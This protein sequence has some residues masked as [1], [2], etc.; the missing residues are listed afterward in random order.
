MKAI[1]KAAA[2]L[3]KIVQYQ[4]GCRENRVSIAHTRAIVNK[5]PPLYVQYQCGCRENHAGMS[6]ANTFF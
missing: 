6:T 4:C 3:K 5:Q 1:P 2:I